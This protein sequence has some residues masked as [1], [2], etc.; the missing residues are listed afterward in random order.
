MSLDFLAPEPIRDGDLPTQWKRFKKTFSQFLTATEKDTAEDKVKIAILLRCI[1]QRG[2]D[3][4]ESFKWQGGK[5]KTKYSDVIGQFDDF[6]QPRCNHVIKRHQL[7]SLKQGTQTIDEFVTA[8]HKIARDCDLKAMYEA[9]VLQAFLLGIESDR[10]RRK[11]FEQSES[12]TLEQ[13]ISVCR[14]AEATTADLQSLKSDCTESVHAIRR[15]QKSLKKANTNPELNKHSSSRGNCSNCG[16]SHPPRQCPAYGQ[17]CHGCLKY[18][19]FSRMCR[20]KRQIHSVNQSDV[21]DSDSDESVLCIAIKEVNNK[22]LATIET[23]TKERNR[24]VKIVYQLD[25]AASCNILNLSDYLKLGSPQITECTTVLHMYDGSATTPMGKCELMVQNKQLS[26]YVMKTTNHS[27]LSMD[28]CLK[29]DLLA[30]NQEYVNLVNTANPVELNTILNDFSDVFS[31]LGCL[32]GE[33]E[34]KMDNSVKPIQN[35]TRKI[36]ISMKNDVKKKIDSLVSKGVLEKVEHPTPWISNMVAVRKPNGT[37]RLCI[38][39]VNLNKAI[40]RNHH[41]M[42]V[43]EDILSDLNGAKIFSLCD[44]K[45]GFLQIKLSPSSTDLTTFWTPFGRYKWNR[46]PFGLSS[47][48]EEFQRR[49]TEAIGNI[50][51]IAVVADD[52][53]IY[54]KGDTVSEAVQD[55]NSKL[56]Q[57][58]IRAREINLKLNKDK[59]RFLLPEIPYIG[60]I[61]TQNGVKPDPNKV[62]AIKEM[63]TPADAEEVRRFLGHI[64]YLAKFIPDLSAESEPLRRLVN[65]PKSEFCWGEDQIRA[66]QKLKEIVTSDRIL[67]YFN[68]NKQ[69]I[70]QTDASTVGLGAALMQEGL[71]VLFASRSLTKCEQNYAPLELECLAIVFAMNKFDQ[72]VFGHPEVIIHTDHQ[73]LETINK[74]SLLKAPKRL[75]SMLLLLQRYSF[76]VKY[77]PGVQQVTADMLSRAPLTDQNACTNQTREE[78]FQAWKANKVSEAVEHVDPTSDK[79]LTDSKYLAIRKETATDPILKQLAVQITHGWATPT[80]QLVDDLKKYHTFR[81]ELAI[82]DGVIYKA[83]R[84]VI[85]KVLRRNI[86]ERLH[87]SHQGAA[88]TI[89]RARNTVYWPNMS[90]DIH[91]HTS[92]CTAC[93]YDAPKLQR[94]TIRHHEIP[95]K[96]WC[97]VGIDLFSLQRQNFMVLSDYLSDFFEIEELVSTEA[98]EVIKVCKKTFA[99]FGVPELVHT[100]N[101]PQ[102]T[103]AEFQK[104]SQEWDFKHTSSSPYHHQSN[105]KAESAVKV[106]KR[107]LKRAKDPYLALLEYRNTPT[108]DMSTSPVERILGRNTR[109]IVPQRLTNSD[110]DVLVLSEK[111]KKKAATEQYYNRA[112]KDLPVLKTGTPVL[113]RDFLSHKTKYL[114]GKIIDSLTDRSYT[115]R[116]DHNDTVVR[117]NRVHIRPQSVDTDQMELDTEVTLHQ[118]PLDRQDMT[119]NESTAEYDRNRRTVH[120]NSEPIAAEPIAAEPIASE[121]RTAEPRATESRVTVPPEH[122]ITRTGRQVRPPTRFNI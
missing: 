51:G 66:F 85:P 121:P 94:E 44:A 84:V 42:P 16:Q 81:D 57:L 28:T 22:L 101:G 33:Y 79:M 2:N 31:G 112:A 18:N 59:C 75:Q 93:Q 62:A 98:S 35:P 49:L 69:I 86:L 58:L 13:A 82:L 40:L 117:R 52:I 20:S 99:R 54:G 38:D 111:F 109:S 120:P 1:G 110:S 12:V 100:D 118:I 26:F 116:M 70:I 105:G 64:N 48:P 27:L 50:S 11:L 14:A 107:L 46:M 24:A 10:L 91:R 43:L 78:V 32:P 29:L 17:Q 47:S 90:D 15:P 19:H 97:K 8:L 68:P 74:K 55:H 103:S 77:V 41:P 108:S 122:Y 23:N 106:A 65:L 104:F 87:S 30:V 25:T 80:S 119:N 96:L 60:H 53:L 7:L 4:F 21:V 67:K 71:P 89:R 3:I 39:P 61:I 72:Y 76:T 9:F 5:S 45:D 73:P 6:C 114:P 113:V 92:L 102:F 36:P 63:V 88:A 37:I 95:N 56:R 115:V 83:N 34:I